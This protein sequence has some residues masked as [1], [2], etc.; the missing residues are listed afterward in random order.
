MGKVYFLPLK[1]P[2]KEELREAGERISELFKEKFKADDNLAIKLHFGEEGSNIYLNPNF[3]K[4]VYE[5]VSENSNETVLVDCNVLYKGKRSVAETHKEVAR[6][7]GF[8]F[9]PILIADGEKGEDEMEVDIEGKHFDKVKIGGKMGNFDSLVAI[10]HLTGHGAAGFGGA[11]KNVGMGLGSKAGKLEMHKAFDLEIDSNECVVCGK[12]VSECPAG[13]IELKADHAK[14]DH[15]KCI[16]CG[17]CISVCP[18]GAVKIPWSASSSKELQEKIVEYAKGVV[19]DRK[20]VFV[21]VL[22]DITSDCDCIGKEKEKMIED[23][24]ILI[25]NDIVSIDAASLDLIGEENLDKEKS[26]PEIQVKY[27]EEIG[28]GEMDYELVEID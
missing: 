1:D 16:G 9:A 5:E 11:L 23:I 22:L 25:S 24:G 18:Q 8:G 4:L 20:T 3:V 14:I 17:R 28:L 10:S 6:E 15:D 12:C 27:A 7:H 2:S 13:A 21:S 26:D 19:K